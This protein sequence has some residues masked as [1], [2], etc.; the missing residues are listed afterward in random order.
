MIKRLFS[1]LCLVALQRVGGGKTSQ[2]LVGTVTP[3]VVGSSDPRKIS[4]L[5]L[6]PGFSTNRHW[7]ILYFFD[8]F[9]RGQTAAEILKTAAAKY[10]YIVAASN[11][12]KNGPMGGSR[13]AAIAMW[14]DTHARLPVDPHRRYVAGLSGG[15]RLALSVPLS[16]GDCV[17]GVIADAAGFPPGATPPRPMRFAL[18]GTIG[19]AYPNYHE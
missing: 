15:A 13:E 17:A 14:D 9:A 4:A 16:C 10:G 5:S 18:F 3:G 11:N 7:P 2:I 8:P 6:P 12:S 1:G 19:D